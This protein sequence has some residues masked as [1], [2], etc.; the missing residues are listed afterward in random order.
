M[1]KYALVKDG[2]VK[3]VVLWNGDKAAYDVGGEILVEV[4]ADTQ[5]GGNWDGKVFTFVEPDPG[6]DT[7]TY[8]EKRKAESP[9]IEECVHAILD[10]D[11]VALQEK[12]TAVKTK[13]PK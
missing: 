5:I 7:R 9:S 12:R 4:T 6:P 10:D 2:I 3:N 1:A 13:Y 8:A 11:L